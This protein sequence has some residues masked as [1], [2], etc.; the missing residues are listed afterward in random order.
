[1]QST[2]PAA[3]K[4][5]IPKKVSD[6]ILEQ[7]EEA[8]ILKEVLPEEQLPPERE[9]ATMFK[10]SRLAVREAIA[11]L[12]AIGLIER[13]LGAKG[14]TFVLPLTAN[15]H[16][17]TREEIK[18]NWDQVK[19]ML[20]FRSIIEPEAARLAAERIT[21]QQLE[22]LGDYVRRSKEEGCTREKFRALDVR[23]H[24]AI[25]SAS[26]NSYI[27]NAV[28]RIRTRINP[29]LDLMPYGPEIKRSTIEMHTML[30]DVLA[31]RDG[32][33][34]SLV[35]KQHIGDTLHAVHSIVFGEQA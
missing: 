33:Q 2:E 34:A 3:F 6:F 9:L 8:I 31:S 5:V 15:A 24:L 16:Q 25:A 21:S 35:M 18:Q 10:V 11:E 20:E 7:L 12:E 22:Q 26:G 13:R 28:R 1:M 23:F 14:G 27:Q 29:I 17:R 19:D 32:D 30:H 4:Q